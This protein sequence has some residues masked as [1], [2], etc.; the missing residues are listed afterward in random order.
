LCSKDLD[1]NVT[2]WNRGAERIFG[3]R[4]DEIIGKSIVTIIPEDLHGEEPE[5]LQR[6]RNGERIEHY[7]TVRQRK[8]GTL[9]QI[10]LTVS[11][12][13]NGAGRIVGVSKIA[14]DISA[15]REAEQQALELS[16]RLHNLADQQRRRLADELLDSLGQ[17]LAAIGSP[18]NEPGF[19]PWDPGRCAEVP[20]AN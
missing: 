16:E 15:R 13:R 20:R 14:R 7:E 11:P 18:R 10:S 1:G 2:S 5:I 4:A 3:Y 9:V 17:H 12:V 6:I 19:V 8:D